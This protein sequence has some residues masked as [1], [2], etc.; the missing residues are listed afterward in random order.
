MSYHIPK[1]SNI[2]QLRD[3]IS[4]LKLPNGEVYDKIM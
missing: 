3:T 2:E 4:E 1:T